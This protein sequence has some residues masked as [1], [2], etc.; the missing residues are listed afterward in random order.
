MTIYFIMLLLWVIIYF[1]YNPRI[2]LVNSSVVIDY[3]S[4]RDRNV[5]K[6]ALW[7]GAVLFIVMSL[8]STAVGTDTLGYAREY[9]LY[10]NTDFSSFSFSLQ[11]EIGYK[12]LLVFFNK[13]GISWQLFLAS[14]SLLEVAGLV[15]IIR[16]YCINVFYGFYLYVTIGVF[17]MNLS[18]LRQSIAIALLLFAVV[19][20][21]NRK[22]LI[23][24]LLVVAACLIHYSSL[25]FVPVYF[26]FIIQYKKKTQLFITLAIPVAV[27]VFSSVL[28]NLL[29]RFSIEK[30][31]DYGY[32]S[33]MNYSISS[34][35]EI[36]SVLIL[37][38]CFTCL[39]LKKNE[40]VTQLDFHFLIMTS[41]Y[42][43]C[44]ELSHVVYMAS[45]L[46]FYFSTFMI[47]MFANAVEGLNNSKIRLVGFLLLLI[48]PMIQFLLT[49]PGSSLGIVPYQFFWQ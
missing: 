2:S 5:Y 37:L 14:V 19:S 20:A 43:S 29:R 11:G 24:S 49:T 30:Y 1:V 9:Q 48:L 44:I 3:N 22:P 21:I 39:M 41:I 35:V 47:V 40:D 7:M 6:I 15:T 28:G 46:S 34:T 26:L 16:R 42:V 4:E 8:R 23:Y 18:G 17:A 38:A 36:V 25:I 12:Y 13:L 45:R 10:K 33:T 31:V 27:R 32:F